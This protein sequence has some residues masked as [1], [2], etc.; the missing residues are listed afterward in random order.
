M[1][2]LQVPRDGQCL[3]F[4]LK[5]WSSP[6]LHSI[7][8]VCVSW[9]SLDVMC[10]VATCLSLPHLYMTKKCNV[11]DRPRQSFLWALS[12]AG[13]GFKL[14]VWLY[15]GLE[16][17]RGIEG[18]S[19]EDMTASWPWAGLRKLKVPPCYP[20]C[21]MSTWYTILIVGATC[22]DE[23]LREKSVVETI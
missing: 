4:T 11:K 8:G 13:I 22:K 15:F 9:F 10:S 12:F 18:G 16:F 19:D 23:V 2:C 3:I 5:G 20:V 6:G 21:A 17:C 7:F 1:H 14:T